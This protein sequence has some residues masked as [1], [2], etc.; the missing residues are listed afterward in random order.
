MNDSGA[1]GLQFRLTDRFG[2]NGMIAV[3]IGRRS[4]ADVDLDTWLMSCRVLGRQVE[5]ATLAVVAQQACEIGAATLVGHYES[6]SKNDMVRD[7]Y[8]RLGFTSKNER[9]GA[10]TWTLDLHHFVPAEGPIEII[11][12]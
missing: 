3:V 1:F 5:A 9:E 6:T 2:D 4:G 8:A 12:G 11:A 7:H 10:S